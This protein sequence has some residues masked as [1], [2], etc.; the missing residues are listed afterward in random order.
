LTWSA[1][2]WHNAFMNVSSISP[3]FPAWI[4]LA[5]CQ[6]LKARPAH[7]IS[8]T[9]ALGSAQPLPRAPAR[10]GQ[11]FPVPTA[12]HTIPEICIALEGSALLKMGRRYYE[13]SPPRLAVIEP[14]VPH[15]EGRVRKGQTYRLLW[16]IPGMSG[17]CGLNVSHCDSL[18]KWIVPHCLHFRSTEAARLFSNFSCDTR[19]AW[20]WE[21]LCADVLAIL[22]EGLREAVRR[23]YWPG[24][25]DSHEASPIERI[26]AYL[27]TNLNHTISVGDIAQMVGLNEDYLGRLFRRVT[28]MSLYA[29][30]TRKR[31]EIAMDLCRQGVLP[32]KQIALSLGYGDPL[33]F[34]RAFRRFHGLSPLQAR[35]L[36]ASSPSSGSEPL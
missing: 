25:S 12:C 34:S 36:G 13:L 23:A 27:E 4:R 6:L 22:A 11:H 9:P 29:F 32:I 15:A 26:T 14:G 3:E 18:G 7:R 24:T 16:V 8:E 20:S 30:L 10:R 19:S 31:M 28:G 21:P 35:G 2:D 5:V 1:A 17:S 33:Y